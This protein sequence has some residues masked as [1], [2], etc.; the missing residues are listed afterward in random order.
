MIRSLVARRPTAV[1]GA[2]LTAG[3]A[4]CGGASAPVP[5]QPGGI[6]PQAMADALHT[7]IES[8][9]TVHA[10]HVV[11][12]LQDA[13]A[14]IT[15]SEHWLDDRALPLP[16]QMV[17]YFAAVYPDVA[18]APQCVNCHSA[19]TDTPRDHFQVGD[20]MGGVVIRNPLR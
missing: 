11:D 8:D 9:R 16:P 14:V 12:R 4:G 3:T 1:R 6:P 13:E 10:R 17:E 19:H 18:V 15:A 7:V 2:A 5:N 20:V